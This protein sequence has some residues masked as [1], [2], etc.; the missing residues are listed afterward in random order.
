MLK[1]PRDHLQNGPKVH[2][3]PLNTIIQVLDRL[4]AQLWAHLSQNTSWYQGMISIAKLFSFHSSTILM[5]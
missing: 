4:T 3:I 5:C 1:H 2:P